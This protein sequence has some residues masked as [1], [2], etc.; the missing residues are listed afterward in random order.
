M[1]RLSPF[2]FLNSINAGPTGKDLLSEC[3]AD[4]SD[5]AILDSNDRDYLPFIVNRGLS[6]FVDAILFA[7]AMNERAHLPAKMQY[8]FLRHA[9][10]PRKRFSK[11]SKK[12]DDTN[13]MKLIMQEYNYSSEKAR[14]A[15]KLFNED[16][17]VELR[18]KHNK[19]GKI[20]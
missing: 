11:W 2:D 3:Y 9:L 18:N 15:L 7:N 5:G 4:S 8:D 6:Y 1:K 13:D 16:T 19:G 14:D 17:L 20:K 10:R 12:I